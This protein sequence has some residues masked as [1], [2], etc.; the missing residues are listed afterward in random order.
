MMR[1][2]PQVVCSCC[3]DKHRLRIDHLDVPTTDDQ[4][5]DVSE[6]A[7]TYKDVL[8]KDLPEAVTEETPKESGQRISK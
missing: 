1:R 7:T 6:P 8:V 2:H 5:P 4:R 3:C